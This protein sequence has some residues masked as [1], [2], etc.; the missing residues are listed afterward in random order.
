METSLCQWRWLS[1]V[2]TQLPR[3]KGGVRGTLI[4]SNGAGSPPAWGGSVSPVES[5]QVSVFGETPLASA[6]TPRGRPGRAALTPSCLP[7]CKAG[8]VR[9]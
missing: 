9:G 8:R 7:S 5:D 3:E 4:L 2:E 1:P 6:G